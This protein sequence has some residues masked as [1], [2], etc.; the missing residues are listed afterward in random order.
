[1]DKVEKYAM[2]ATGPEFFEWILKGAIEDLTFN[3]L[4]QQGMP[5]ER[6]AYYEKGG[7]TTI[8]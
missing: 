3:D 4:G 6:M 1:M 7:N 2:R 5:L 8:F